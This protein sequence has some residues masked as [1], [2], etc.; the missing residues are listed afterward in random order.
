MYNKI[1][2][3]YWFVAARL[4]AEGCHLNSSPLNNYWKKKD[5]EMGGW[6]FIMRINQ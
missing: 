3:F 5:V 4:I 6:G 1:S 2:F